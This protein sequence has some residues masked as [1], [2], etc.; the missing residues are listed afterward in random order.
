ML[1][2]ASIHE[3]CRL[4]QRVLPVVGYRTFPVK[5]KDLFKYEDN[6]KFKISSESIRNKKISFYLGYSSEAKVY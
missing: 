1:T 2:V 3:C 6:V 5:I 4:L